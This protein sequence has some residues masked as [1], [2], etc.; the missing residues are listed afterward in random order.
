MEV[1]EVPLGMMQKLD[2][3]R[4]APFSEML[5]VATL[6]LAMLADKERGS[7]R[8]LHGQQ[9]ILQKRLVSWSHEPHLR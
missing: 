8:L 4:R 2:M 7:S 3:P 1:A 6:P 5:L 9:G